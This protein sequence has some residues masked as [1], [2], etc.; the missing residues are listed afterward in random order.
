MSRAGRQAGAVGMSRSQA[1]NTQTWDLG[2]AAS[3][4]DEDYR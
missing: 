3:V 1:S 2:L 4:R